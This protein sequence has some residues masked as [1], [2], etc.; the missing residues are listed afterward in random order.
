MT[1][2]ASRAHRDGVPSLR[3]SRTTR[4]ERS[5]AIRTGRS[6]R[7]ISFSSNATDNRIE[8]V[9]NGS[10]DGNM[11]SSLQVAGFVRISIETIR[12]CESTSTSRSPMTT[13]PN[14]GCI[15]RSKKCRIVSFNDSVQSDL[16]NAAF[17]GSAMQSGRNLNSSE[18]GLRSSGL[19][20]SAEGVSSGP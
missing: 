4:L 20:R 3:R 9:G 18:H 13:R 12:P 16:Q 10:G 15:P 2:L 11:A 5:R 6:Y 14:A 17:R 8:A 7:A 19:S 1:S